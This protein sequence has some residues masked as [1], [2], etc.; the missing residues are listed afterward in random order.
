[1]GRQTAEGCAKCLESRK[2]LS[3]RLHFHEFWMRH[4]Q[5]ALELCEMIFTPSESAKSY[6]LQ[7][8][9]ELRG[10]T[11]VIP[12]GIDIDGGDYLPKPSDGKLR[13]A[14][15]GGINTI[16]GA[17]VILKMIRQGP[18]WIDWSIIGGIGDRELLTL[19]RKN[20]WQYGWYDRNKLPELL[21]EK[22][23]DVVCLPS[24]SA[25]TFCYTLSEVTACHIPC[26][27][28]DIGALGERVKSMGFGW[29]VPIDS[30][31]EDMLSILEELHSH[32]SMITDAGRQ[33]AGYLHRSRKEMAEDYRIAYAKLP[34]NAHRAAPGRKQRCLPSPAECGARAAQHPKCTQL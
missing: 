16:K 34:Q 23:I 17:D 15:V 7:A 20:L 31:A 14:F 22:K 2:G 19:Q 25:E 12:H 3:T 30:A 11:Q 21:S 18:S 27:V 24:L 26:I 32:P 9:P 33:A 1:M 6:L 10:K 28:T 5:N 29:T 8:Y 4:Y 13:V